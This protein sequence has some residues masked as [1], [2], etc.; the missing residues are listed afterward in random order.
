MQGENSE[1]GAREPQ[2]SPSQVPSN[3]VLFSF[4]AHLLVPSTLQK[5]SQGSRAREPNDP[6][7]SPLHTCT[8]SHPISLSFSGDVPGPTD[9]LLSA[10]WSCQASV[11]ERCPAH[12]GMLGGDQAHPAGKRTTL[13]DDWLANSKSVLVSRALCP[14]QALDPSL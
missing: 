2:A 3:Q 6:T 4:H 13:M 14:M 12:G 5:T 1:T 8:G 10:F 7:L 9:K 11:S